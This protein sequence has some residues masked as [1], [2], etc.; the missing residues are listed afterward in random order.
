M[1]WYA[2]WHLSDHSFI[3]A[4]EQKSGEWGMAKGTR[5]SGGGESMLGL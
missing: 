5:A 4:V 3:N 2:C 1:K